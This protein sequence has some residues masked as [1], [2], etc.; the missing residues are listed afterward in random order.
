M[1]QQHHRLAVF[2]RAAANASQGFGQRHLDHFDVLALIGQAAARA[3]AVLWVVLRHEKCR[4]S[5]TEPGLMWASNTLRGWRM[6]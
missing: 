4:F 6:R 3:N 5:V 2:Y 1:L